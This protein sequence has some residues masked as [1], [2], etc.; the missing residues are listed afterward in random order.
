MESLDYRHHRIHVNKHTAHYEP[1]GS[2][3]IVLAHRDPGPALPELARYLPARPGRHALP[4]DRA[5]ARTIRPVRTRV[6][7]LSELAR[8]SS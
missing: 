4:L 6:V 2:L 8:S 5:A 1:D 3:R 7:R